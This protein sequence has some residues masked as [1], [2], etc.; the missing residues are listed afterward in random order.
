MYPDDG[1]GTIVTNQSIDGDADCSMSAYLAVDSEYLY[2]AFDITDDVN[3]V[4]TTID[5]YK[6]DGADL[7]IGTYN[8]HGKS[9]TGLQ[10]GL[11]PD[12]HFR[13]VS[14]KVIIDNA[15]AAIVMRP[16]D[17]YIFH[18]DFPSGYSIEGKIAFAKLIEIV[19]ANVLY[20]PDLGH[21]I[22][23]DFA[24]NDAD[25]TGEREGI[26]T[27][28]P[29]NE[30]LSYQEVNRWLYTWIGDSM[31]SDVNG[32][33]G[34]QYKFDL[35]Q[36]YPNPFNPSTTINYSVP[37]NGLVTL[38]IFN[39]LGQEVKTLV[40]NVQNAGLH[41]V[42]FN[43]SSLASGVYIYRLSSGNFVG[44]KKMLLLK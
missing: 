38:K 27:Y 11:E 39:V 7:F 29:Y 19:P 24:V 43:A 28:S 31:I 42:S 37:T 34:I 5:T 18:E 10:T 6:T 15:G 25:A 44:V 3:S 21:R 12:Y 17:D 8:W 26:L 35:S 13:F 9:H 30:D 22:P 20:T 33:E 16:G 14:N 41:T 1:S 2:F 32:D 40:N 23:I 36:N 4:D